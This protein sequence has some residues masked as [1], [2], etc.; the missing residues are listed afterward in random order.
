M[1]VVGFDNLDDSGFT[2]PGLTTVEPGNAEMADA[3]CA[4]LME[5]IE[6]PPVDGTARVVMPRP[7]IVHR[8]STRRR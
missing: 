8:G 6:G 4:L 1:Q 3:I 5:R 2:V 7:R